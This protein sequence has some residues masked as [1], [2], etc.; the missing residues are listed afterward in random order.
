MAFISELHYRSGDAGDE[1][2]FVEVT[3]GPGED[4][5]DFTLSLYEF[6]GLIA[7]STTAGDANSGS[8]NAD[9]L[10]GSGEISLAS[11]TGIPD[12]DNPD[13]TIFRIQGTVNSNLLIDGTPTDS[14]DEVS[15]V[16]LFDTAN[17]TLID[18]YSVAGVPGGTTL[19]GGAADGENG[20]V[21]AG[22]A[23]AGESIQFDPFGIGTNGTPFADARTPGDALVPESTPICFAGGCTLKTIK[24][25]MPVETIEVG[26]LLR[27]LDNGYQPVRF[28]YRRKMRALGSMRPVLFETGAI[29]NSAP[30][31]VSQQH[32]FLT[33]SLPFEIRQFYKSG[34]NNLVKASEL[35]NGTTIRIRNDLET[36]EYFHFML[37]KHELL[38]SAGTISES[39]Q[40]HRRNLKRD[41]ALRE[42]LLAIF[43]EI[44]AKREKWVRPEVSARFL[45]WRDSV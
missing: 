35:V 30:I 45:P 44:E 27:T 9:V 39:W 10:G 5:A 2:E 18:G 4:P 43:P 21:N 22:T 38:Y 19:S 28:V 42:E 13:F 12:P 33:S 32:R 34:E 24:G 3:L 31:Q 25:E 40:P 26:D 15:F 36:V 1:N 6:D 23:G 37:D 11:L 8:P 14:N 7:T 41:A 29:G 17:G 16:T 20:T